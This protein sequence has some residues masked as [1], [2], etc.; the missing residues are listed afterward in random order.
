MDTFF[1]E[2]GDAVL[3]RWK[4]QNFSLAKFPRI[5]QAALD[6]RPPAT[7]VDLQKLMRDFLL[8]EEQPTQTDSPF[9]E[10]EIVVYHHSRFYIQLLFW[11]DG[12]TAIHQ[13]A[14]SGAFHVMKGS[15]IHA[16]YDFENARAVT[17]HLSVGNVRM[18]KIE[19][20]ETG[21]TVPIS[22]GRQT[23][24][25]LFHLD[26]PSV[27]VV[28]RT[29][30]DPGTGPQFNYLPPHMAID[31]L[32]SDLL[33]LR[34]N[35]LLGVLEQTEDESYPELVME[36]LSDLDFERGFH[37][38][39]QSMEYLQQLGEW[40]TAIKTFK[41]K[42]GS[43]AAGVAATLHEEVR[44]SIIKSLRS[45]IIEPEHRFFL[46]LLMNCTSRADLFSL[47]KQRYP[48]EA[49]AAVI[50]RWVAELME[51][52]D[53]SVTILDAAFPEVIEVDSEIRP[54]LFL[55][56]FRH[57]MKRDKKLPSVMHDLST[58]DLSTLRYAFAES[59]LGLLTI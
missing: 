24:H 19:I 43:L 17:P 40:D 9:G 51:A 26:S 30:H 29:Q 42:H 25:S 18:R 54:E 33:T 7:R 10:P 8:R 6:E 15:S 23:I 12:T 49:P 37:V 13:H 52:T 57:F 2:L 45:T 22:S 50:E 36:M 1:K 27:T 47:L 41:K 11:L 21:R 38:L 14:F 55:A 44:R 31:P 35:Q 53:E 58:E 5:A 3:E 20:L 4:R 46:A 39:Q 16:H 32:H 48:R 59:T 34:R 56:A 28:V